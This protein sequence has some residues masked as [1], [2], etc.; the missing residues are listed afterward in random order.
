MKRS[1]EEWHAL[2]EAQPSSGLGVGSYCRQHQV[3]S[4]CFY[5][6]RRLLTGTSGAMSPWAAKRRRT[7]TSV[8]PLPVI[9]GFATVQV[10]QGKIGPQ[11]LPDESIRL[12]LAGGRELILPASMPAQRLVELLVALENKPS[13]LERG[14]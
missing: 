14:V 1:P 7:S 3:T 10:S 13:S 4:S 11:S 5:R 8:E 9:Q 12:L 2:I 6:W